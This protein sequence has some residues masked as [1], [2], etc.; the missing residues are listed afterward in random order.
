MNT[1]QQHKNTTNRPHYRLATT[2][3]KDVEE[4]G[5]NEMC[6]TAVL[7]KIQIICYSTFRKFGTFGKLFYAHFVWNLQVGF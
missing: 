6:F 5:D 3:I 2:G 7:H 4:F 1:G